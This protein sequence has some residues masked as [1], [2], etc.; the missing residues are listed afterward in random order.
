VHELLFPKKECDNPGLQREHNA[1]FVAKEPSSSITSS[2]PLNNP[3][4]RE[5]RKRGR[6]D[7]SR[8][9]GSNLDTNIKKLEREKSSTWKRGR[10]IRKRL[11][12]NKKGPVFTSR[13]HG[14]VSPKEQ[15][16][17]DVDCVRIL[18]ESDWILENSHNDEGLKFVT[19][20][21]SCHLSKESADLILSSFEGTT[22]KAYKA[23][24]SVFVEFLLS[25][26]GII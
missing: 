13:K 23:G 5:R 10:Y 6:D 25:R 11:I 7:S 16:F 21:L 26:E 17:N 8:L 19:E 18:L 24:W 15:A 4:I 3:E 22:L 12:N 20:F 2:Y 14:E 9:E 1:P